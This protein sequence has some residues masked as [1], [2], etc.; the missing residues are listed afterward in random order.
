M[1]SRML[2]LP[3]E[4]RRRYD[5]SSLQFALHGAGPCPVQVKERMIDW[6][7]P[8]IHEYYGATEGL[9]MTVCNSAEW[10]AHR[11]TVGK[12][13]LGELH[14]MNESMQPLPT[15]QAGELWFKT[16]APFE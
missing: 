2:K 1:F 13:V 11:G 6:W 8:I 7:G 16:A 12:V 10:L 15:G 4:L 3:E 5:L 14:V 9:G